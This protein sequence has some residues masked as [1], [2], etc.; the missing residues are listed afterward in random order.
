L[1]WH[2]TRTAQVAVAGHGAGIVGELHPEV[3]A[4]FEVPER[5]VAFELAVAPLV[6]ALQ[7][8]PEVGELPRLPPIYLDLAVVVDETVPAAAVERVIWA[9]G[10]P[11]VTSVRLFDLYRGEQVP[12]GRKSLAYALEL[13]SRERTLTDQEAEIVRHRIT[14]ALAER[15]GGELRS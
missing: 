9:A 7:G 8:R 2:P 11:E 15:V 3:C 6:E 14:T 13:R 10:A 1:P 4:R 12:D 5:T